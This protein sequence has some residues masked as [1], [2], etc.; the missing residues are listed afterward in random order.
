MCGIVGYVGIKNAVEVI[1]DGLSRLEYR[2][3]DS[4]GICL[5]DK[6]GKLI[7]YKKTGKLE[8]LTKVL[9]EESPSS[10][11]IG[12]GH[13]RWATHGSVTDFN[14]HP[15]GNEK[16]NVVH[17]GNIENSKQ[18]KNRLESEGWTFC[19]ETDSEVFLVLL[20]KYLQTGPN[21]SPLSLEEAFSL[22]FE[23]IEGN[24]AF[25]AMER[26]SN[27]IV[28][29]KKGAPIVCGQSENGDNLF[30]ASDPYALLGHT[31]EVFFPE[32]GV[33]CLL[34]PDG[35]KKILFKELNGRP[36]SRVFSQ[37][38]NRNLR[39][40]HRGR[41]DH[42]MLKE[43]YEQPDLIRKFA[44]H[45]THGEGSHSLENIKNLTPRLFHL[46]ACGSAWHAGL[47]LKNF[48]EKDNGIP[49]LVDL[50]SEFRYRNPLLSDRDIGLFIS[51]SGETADTL[52]AQKL[53][54]EHGLQTISIINIEGSTLYRKS[55]YNLLIKAGQE[56]G[57]ASTKAFTLMVLTGHLFSQKLAS[58]DLGQ[59]HTKM[60]ELADGIEK[61]L[62]MS[63]RIQE[64][65]HEIY[66]K[67][68]FLYT[69]RGK[70]F[71]IALEGALKLKEIAYVHA[72]GY[73][74]GELKH[75]PIALIDQDM[76]NIA[77][78]GP[79]L[80]GKT[81]SNIEEVRARN[82]I[83]VIIG[84]QGDK[85][86]ERLCRYYLPLDFSGSSELNPLLV[87]VVTQL[88]AYYMARYK[89]TDIDR[90][91]NLAKSVTVE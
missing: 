47:C 4:A 46:S 25:V 75:G 43:I 9:V 72:E 37:K 66:Q 54:L 24:S 20:T 88:L 59:C 51:Q 83:M 35:P 67:K 23:E 42:Y 14:A 48:V 89:G 40:S 18:L 22:A 1:L 87:N 60:M 11:P 21:G 34:N 86:L 69:G 3:Y 78:I 27:K 16:I 70:Y 64:V 81:L 91:R 53:C 82:G 7:Q 45:Y 30:V 77:L 33:I 31:N 79:E 38:Q 44:D 36:S 6:D 26:G 12:I 61:V 13:T 17:N 71:P 76:V 50:A 39:P 2:G 56:I 74:A 65:A 15:H 90:P 85:E 68:G 63:D 55:D 52:A 49:V 62:S 57:V 80:Y 5:K 32:D 58:N 41:F 28:A 8:N 84:P 73:A 29:V 19:S 10:S